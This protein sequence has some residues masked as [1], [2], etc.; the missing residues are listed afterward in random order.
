MAKKR[1]QALKGIVDSRSF[2][3]MNIWPK[4]PPKKVSTA[5]RRLGISPALSSEAGHVAVPKGEVRSEHAPRTAAKMS[6]SAKTTP[7]TEARNEQSRVAAAKEFPTA[8]SQEKLDEAVRREHA[9]WV[10]WARSAE[11]AAS[12]GLKKMTKAQR[13]KLGKIKPEFEGQPRF[14]GGSQFSQGGLPTLGKRR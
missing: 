11:R 7:N 10:R 4:E 5:I 9:A 3:M 12:T 13:R 1:K 6:K 14:E 2:A 8:N